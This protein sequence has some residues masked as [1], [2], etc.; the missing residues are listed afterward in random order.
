MERLNPF[1]RSILKPTTAALVALG[2]GALLGYWYPPGTNVA[3]AA[4]QADRGHDRVRRRCSWR[5]GSRTTTNSSSAG[6]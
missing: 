2:S 6:P 3:V 1:D 4:S 5:C